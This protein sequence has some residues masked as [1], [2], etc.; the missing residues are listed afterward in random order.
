MNKVFQTKFNDEGNCFAACVASM[1][2]CDIDEVPH[3]GIEEEWNE[4]EE[5][6]NNYLR[7]NYRTV[8]T[9]VPYDD[10]GDFISFYHKDSYYIV[11]GQSERGYEHAVI[12]KNELMVHDPHPS[13]S[14]VTDMKSIFF[15]FK[16]YFD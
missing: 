7:E 14:G 10:W 3:L 8:L 4:Y 1:L 16:L 5:R 2:K 11:S 6:L 15:F 13:S 12:S 9:H